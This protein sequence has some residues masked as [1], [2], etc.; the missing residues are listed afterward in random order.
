MKYPQQQLQK[1]TECMQSLSQYFE[2]EQIPPSTIHYMIYQNLSSGQ[3]HNALGFSNSKLVRA[4]Q[5]VDGVKVVA[6]NFVRLWPIDDS[7]V[8]YPEGCNDSHVETAVKLAMKS[9]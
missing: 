4:S 2:L 8:L 1:L 9:V 3:Q 7:F 6:E 5:F